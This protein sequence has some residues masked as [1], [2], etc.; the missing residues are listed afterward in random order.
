MLMYDEVPDDGDYKGFVMRVLQNLHDS[1]LSR[2][3]ASLRCMTPEEQLRPTCG[4]NGKMHSQIEFVEMLRRRRD[5]IEAA[6][7]W[8]ESRPE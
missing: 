7:D 4:R 1:S 6:I 3:E 5:H 8:V 2:A